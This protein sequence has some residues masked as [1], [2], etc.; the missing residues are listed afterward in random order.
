[1][2]NLKINEKLIRF[3]G[4]AGIDFDVEIDSDVEFIVKGGIVKEM[5]ESNQDG[6]KDQIF[7]CKILEVKIK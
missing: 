5:F 2:E 4:K 1:M 3:S 6:T 7:T